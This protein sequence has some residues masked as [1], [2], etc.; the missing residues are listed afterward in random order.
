[1]A[2]NILIDTYLFDV[3]KQ[4]CMSYCSFIF[5]NKIPFYKYIYK[6][7]DTIIVH[8]PFNVNASIPDRRYMTYLLSTKM[9]F[10]TNITPRL[11]CSH[12]CVHD[13]TEICNA[14]YVLIKY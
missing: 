5:D 1:M 7:V 2:V 8:P 14:D 13:L 3:F 10:S 6:T 11:F 12:N 9:G 4:K